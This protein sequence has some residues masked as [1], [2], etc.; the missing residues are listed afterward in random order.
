VRRCFNLSESVDEYLL[1][2]PAMVS[3]L[4]HRQPL[5]SVE[6][7]DTVN[8]NSAFKFPTVFT[9]RT[10]NS[11]YS[12]F[13]PRQRS[14]RRGWCLVH[15][16]WSLSLGCTIAHMH[17][18]QPFSQPLIALSATNLFWNIGQEQPGG[19]YLCTR[20]LCLDHIMSLGHYQHRLYTSCMPLALARI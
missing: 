5:D 17:V 12:M 18:S 1:R 20:N 11:S 8:T 15:A 19:G 13:L 7:L 3:C 14:R 2:P 16:V 9:L 10:C 6:V 4:Y